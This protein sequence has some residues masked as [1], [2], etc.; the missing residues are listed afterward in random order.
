MKVI[1]PSY[2][3][4]ILTFS[5]VLHEPTCWEVHDN[6]Q[7]QTFRNRTYISNDRGKHILSIPII[8]VGK[9]QGRQKY[10]DVLIDN[11]Y[12]WQRQHWRTLQTAYRTSPFFEFYEDEIK[13]L[14]DQPYDKL[15]DYNLK[16][17]ETIFEC[18][19][20]EMPKAS[21]K[22]FEVSLSEHE[23]FRFL[24]NAKLK[25]NLTI[26]PYTQ[27]FGDRHGFIPNL[28]ILDLLFN[29]GPNSI[30]YLQRD[31]IDKDNA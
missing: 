11:S 3:P 17:I 1:H 8:H 23:D 25:H 21:T 20:M 31:F 5:H 6:Y 27:V 4:N 9:E 18:L 19:Q 30:E 29:M 16:T 2:F 28:S 12:S 24:I 22:E 10:K 14:Y 15:L 7:K 13:P 26:E